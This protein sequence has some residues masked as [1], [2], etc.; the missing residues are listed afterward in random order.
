MPAASIAVVSV[1]KP[2][3]RGVSHQVAFFV[4]LVAGG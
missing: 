4:A 3:L 2:F 1:E